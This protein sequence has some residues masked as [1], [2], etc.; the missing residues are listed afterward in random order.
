MTKIIVAFRNIANAPKTLKRLKRCFGGGGGGRTIIC[1]N[2]VSWG[3]L[4]RNPGERQG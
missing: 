4:E 3:I 2:S 1:G